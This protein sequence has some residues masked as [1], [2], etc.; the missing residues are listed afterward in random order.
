MEMRTLGS[1]GIKVSAIGLG[2]M[3]MSGIYGNANDEESIRVIHYA[4][5][6]GINMLDSADMYGWGHNEE[7]LG[8]ALKGWR[9]G[10][11]RDGVIVATKFGQTKSADGKQGVDGSPAYVLRACEASLKRLGIDVI[12][13]Y[14][15]H[16]VDPNVPIEETVGAMKRLV[17]AGKVRALGLSEAAPATIRRAHKIHPIAAVQ[18]EYSLLYRKEGEET[19]AATRELGIS[20][21]A[22]APLGRSMLTG[23]VKGKADLPEGDRRLAHPRF[24]GEALDKNVKIVKRIEE[25]AV[26][27]KCTPAQLVLAW[28]LA[29]GKDIVPIPGTKRKQRVDENLAA[30]DVKLSPQEVERISEIAPVGAG[31]GLRY[32]AEGLKRVYL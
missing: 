12:D 3:S 21:V 7:L 22:Y 31:S 2:L 1:S 32:P 10:G 30:L 28:L 13:L 17:E 20:L 16:R 25:I 6:K 4:L 26:E 19:L 11:R 5:E 14:Y 23:S 9:G 27:K 8:K 24:Q 29:Q 18:N 15:Q